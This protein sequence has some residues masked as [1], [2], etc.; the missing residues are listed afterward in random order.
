MP[1]RL[2]LWKAGRG[3]A[4]VAKARALA[5]R[6]RVD[7]LLDTTIDTISH[8]QRRQVEVGMALASDP[9]LL[10]LDEPAAGLSAGERPE[11]MRLIR[12]LPRELTLILIEHDMDVA[13]P[14]SDIV[15][16]MKDGE[17]VVENTPDRIADD[18]VVQAIYLGGAVP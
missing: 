2:S 1:G 6:V 4:A 5:E 11:L 7:G 12:D 9:R 16:V 10:M 8:G 18:P 17:V 3:D 13:L 15:T 14:N